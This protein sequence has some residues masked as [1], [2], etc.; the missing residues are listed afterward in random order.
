M[1]PAVLD[2]CVLFQGKLTNLLLWLAAN[3]VF[4]PAWSEAI[5]DEWVRNLEASG[6]L[7]PAKIAYRAAEMEKAF[8]SATVTASRA[9]HDEIL[10][11]C[12]TEAQR[13]DAHVIATA[14]VA[15]AKIIVTAN[16]RDFA[17]D[18]LARYALQVMTPDDFCCALYSK[19]VDAFLKGA[20]DHRQSMLRPSYTPEAYI[21][22]LDDPS[23]GLRRTAD[24]LRAHE[25]SL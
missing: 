9:I 2:A 19:D 6:R 1:E 4:D 16:I 11:L 25:S 12:R 15:E 5:R 14:V 18:I 7:P 8:P 23:F 22:L 13:K 24:L 20:R 10:A 21:G 17:A 3:G